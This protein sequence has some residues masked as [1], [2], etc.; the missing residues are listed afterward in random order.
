MSRISGISNRVDDPVALNIMWNRLV[1]ISEECWLTIWRTA[2]SIII[3][4]VQDFACDI[5]DASGYSLAHSPRSMPAFSLTLPR[6]AREVLARYPA[7]DFHVGDVFITNDPWICVGHLPDLAVLSPVLRDRR[8]VGFIGSIAHCSD[9]GGT[10]DSAHARE[11]YEEGLQIPPI[12]FVTAGVVSPD[13]VALIRQN[14]RNPDMVLGDIQA[15]ISANRVGIDRLLAFMDEY[16]LDDLS[17]L[18]EVVQGRAEAAMRAAVGAIP[19]GF[20][21]HEVELSALGR[22]LRLPIQIRVEGDDL[23]VTYDGAPPQVEQGA[24]NSTLS[25][26]E[27]HTVYALKCLLT[28]DIFSNAGC[29]R[30][31]H[32]DAPDGSIMNC[33]YPAAVNIR[34]VSGWYCAP[35]V[36]GALAAVLPHRVQAFTGLPMGAGAYGFERDGRRFNDSLL[37]GGGLG[38]SAQ[39]D[40][41]SAVLF[42]TS[43]AN[44]SIELYESRTPLLVEC[45]ELIPDSGGAGR[46]RGGLGQRLRIR[47]LY[48]DGQPVLFSLTP[49]GI[50]VDTPGLFGG[51]HGKRGTVRLEDAS[52]IV[53]VD[54]R[55]AGEP[56]LRTTDQRIILELAGGSGYGLA[57]ERPIEEVQADLDRGLVTTAGLADYGCSLDHDGRVTR[58]VRPQ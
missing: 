31:F 46:H 5:L 27:A 7:S 56:E 14:V 8:L 18:A 51:R 39:G 29:Y 19:D 36:F 38:G 44:T 20:Y 40:G 33:R 57:D 12:R 10:R 48:E 42:P 55:L 43:A 41:L 37:Q 49:H 1:G 6:A 9:I 2:F 47:K 24:V 52:G 13:V 25:Y 50:G 34:T 21:T 3:G 16:D 53:A 11:V 58:R 35:A 23:Y 22:P 15:Q 28:P 4:E 30:P 17:E 54:N 45:K 32:V 26:T